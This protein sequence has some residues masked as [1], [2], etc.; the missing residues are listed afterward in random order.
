[1]GYLDF[2][3]G[4]V[5]S[6][7]QLVVLRPASFVVEEDA[8]LQQIDGRGQ[9]R[10]RGRGLLAGDEVQLRHLEP[11]D[12]VRNEAGP[13]VDLV[14]DGEQHLLEQLLAGGT[15]AAQ[16]LPPN[17]HVHRLPLLRGRQGVRRLPYLIVRKL[18]RIAVRE[19]EAVVDQGFEVNVDAIGVVPDAQVQQLDGPLVEA[20]A[21]AR[22]HAEDPLDLLAV[23]S[24]H[25]QHEVDGVVGDA[26]GA[27]GVDVPLPPAGA[28]RVLEEAGV[29]QR[30]EELDDEQ[31]VAPRLGVQVGRQRLR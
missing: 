24:H 7:A 25:G 16:E 21:Q 4:R 3:Q 22:R 12:R 6:Q 9:E 18:E 13:S 20:R 26:L 15:G 8:S 30:L 5:Q 17:L 29:V 23:R 27:D 19:E 2:S 14:D 31:G 1:M 10:A 11:L 28:G